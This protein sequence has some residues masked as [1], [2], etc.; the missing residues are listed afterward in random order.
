MK[1]L[2]S[3]CLWVALAAILSVSG[4]ATLSEEDCVEGD[5]YGIGYRD[6]TNGYSLDRIDSHNE[7]CAEFGQRVN[8]VDYMEGR[9]EGLL[10]YCT[11][12]SGRRVGEQGQSYAGVCP[13]E[14]EGEFLRNYDLGYRFYELK[15]E[16]D[17][18]QRDLYDVQ[19]DL[20]DDD[21]TKEERDRLR[22]EERSLQRELRTVERAMDALRFY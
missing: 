5:W 18:I 19:D 8:R 11:P 10:E 20:D 12:E 4:C 17:R 3:S 21:L 14:M 9:D 2:P 22:S 16:R 1:L 13:A 15:L 6:G 7:A